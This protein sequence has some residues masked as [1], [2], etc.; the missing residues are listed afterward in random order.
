MAASDAEIAFE[1]GERA[2][3][4]RRDGLDAVEFLLAA[5]PAEPLRPLASVASGGERSR[6]MLALKAAPGIASVGMLSSHVERLALDLLLVLIQQHE[7]TKDLEKQQTEH[8]Q[9]STRLWA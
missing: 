2:Y 8:Q 9:F 6:L 4:V 1:V 7:V 5:G 3:R